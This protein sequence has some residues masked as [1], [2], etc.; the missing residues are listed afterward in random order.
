MLV[1]V[2]RTYRRIVG[3]GDV[4]SG[5]IEYGEVKKKVARAGLKREAL[6]HYLLPR[7]LFVAGLL[8]FHPLT[9]WYS[10]YICTVLSV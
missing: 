9:I 4:M 2:G 5:E 3:F 8:L 6:T 1:D 7:G 10:Q